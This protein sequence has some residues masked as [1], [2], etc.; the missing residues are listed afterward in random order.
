MARRNRHQRRRPGRGGPRRGGPA[1]RPARPHGRQLR[2]LPRPE[3]RRVPQPRSGR[4]ARLPLD[5]TQV[6]E[7]SDVGWQWIREFG[8][9]T[10]WRP[11][12]QINSLPPRAVRP[13]TR[14]LLSH[15][16]H[17]SLVPPTETLRTHRA[18]ARQGV[19]SEVAFFR[20]EAHPLSRPGNIRAWYR[21]ILSA[22]ADEM[23]PG[24]PGLTPQEAP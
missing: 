10:E 2:W 19:R 7:G 1:G 9:P 14:V 21:W 23:T 12:Y 20:S 4:R 11:L 5:L 24:A 15:G 16:L 17:D 13:G 18:L 22:V 6:A 8:D 3:H